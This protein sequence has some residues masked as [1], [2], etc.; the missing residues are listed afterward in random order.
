[1]GNQSELTKCQSKNGNNLCGE[2]RREE[3]KRGERG[4]EHDF[5]LLPK[6]MHV[7]L[8]IIFLFLLFIYL[9]TSKCYKVNLHLK[10]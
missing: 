10:H 9:L 5:V 7:I 2:E 3:E 4:E 1:M 6:K 8:V